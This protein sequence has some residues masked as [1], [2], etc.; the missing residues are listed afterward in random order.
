LELT[1]VAATP[2]LELAKAFSVLPVL[3]VFGQ[4]LDT[5]F[6]FINARN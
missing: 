5:T 2:G 6:Y 1:W 4:H 3:L